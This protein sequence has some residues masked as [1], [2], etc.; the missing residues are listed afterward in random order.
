[1]G[2]LV[3]ADAEN[4]GAEDALG[5]RVD[6]HLHEALVSLFS[7]PRLTRVMGRVATRAGRPEARTWDSVMPPRPSGGSTYRA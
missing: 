4:G 7:T 2:D 5:L 3:A 6:Q 1:M